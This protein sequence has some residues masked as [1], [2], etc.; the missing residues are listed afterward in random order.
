V[1]TASQSAGSFKL[2]LRRRVNLPRRGTMSRGAK[3]SVD[4]LIDKAADDVN[5]IDIFQVDPEDVEELD[6]N[7]LDRIP[8]DPTGFKDCPFS[9][10]AAFLLPKIQEKISRSE[11]RRPPR[12]SGSIREANQCENV[13]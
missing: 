10:G 4:Q 2:V 13:G 12:V 5:V 6:L 1:T 3:S 8:T 11:Q 9:H 7:H